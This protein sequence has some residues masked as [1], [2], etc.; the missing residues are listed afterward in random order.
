MQ[1]PDSPR[2]KERGAILVHVAVSL[3]ML[4][5]FLVF[6]LDYGVVLTSRGQAQNSADGGALAGAIAWAF[7]DASNPPPAGGVVELSAT[8]VAQQNLVWKESGSVGV[9][10]VCP[11]GVTGGGCVQV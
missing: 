1:N 6:V 3:L 5:G 4:M 9:S 11:P 8:Q 7:D 10:Y 2:N